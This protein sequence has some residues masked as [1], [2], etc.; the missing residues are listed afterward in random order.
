MSEIKPSETTPKTDE[1]SLTFSYLRQAA[2]SKEPDFTGQQAKPRPPALLADPAFDMRGQAWNP[3][4]DAATPLIGLVIRLR[5]LD[6]HDDVPALCL[7]VSNQ[8]ITIMEEVSQLDYDAGMLKAYSYSLCLLVDEV[9]MRTAWGRLSSWGARS[10]LSQFHG[11][12]QGGEKFFTVMNNMIPEAARYQHVLEFMYQCLISGLKGKYGA[13]IKGDDELQKII[14]Q[15]HDLLRPL[16]GETS[17]RLTDP[18]KNVAPRNY[19]ITRAWPL[20]APWALAAA[21]LT[22]ACTIYSMRLNTITQQVL[23]S[24]ERVLQL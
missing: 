5:R 13:H 24:L 21:V 17:K 3:L 6:Q 19:R 15:L 20:W 11:E 22:V 8:I 10:L 12:T 2:S 16:R 9:V 1:N 14:H 18:L 7:S 4:C 23:V